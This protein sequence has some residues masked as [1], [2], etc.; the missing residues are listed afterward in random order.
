M[1]KALNLNPYSRWFEIVIEYSRRN[2]TKDTDI[3]PAL[4][5][6]ARAF[7]DITKDRYCAGMWESELLQSLCW[8]RQTV[9][10]HGTKNR[11]N[12]PP[13]MDLT[14]PTAYRA[15]SWSWA[16]VNGGR[17][18]MYNTAIDNQI[19]IKNIATPLRISLEPLGEDLY[20]ELKSGFLSIKGS[21]FTLGD[22]C[23]EYWKAVSESWEEYKRLPPKGLKSET[24]QYPALHEYSLSLLN[25]G[26]R[27]TFEFEQQHRRHPNQTFT[28]FLIAQ[29]EGLSE[30]AR[31]NE[32]YP[33]TG[34]ANLLLLESTG[35]KNEY[36]RIGVLNLGRPVELFSVV[37]ET[38]RTETKKW[39][40]I[41]DAEWE[42]FEKIPPAA[43]GV[44]EAKAWV[45]IAK[46]APKRTTIRIV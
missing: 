9:Q 30:E 12:E 26:S 39:K 10:L 16:A 18:T 1:E 13:N 28:A 40:D 5:G 6:V 43:V 24:Y 17:V 20:G 38:W 7:S 11:M 46:L 19:A 8:W 45:E 34:S 27:E 44:P 31:D 22:L 2:Y 29:V 36:R 14:K 42:R 37:P 25:K 21:L 3:L 41:G 15:P 35:L 4:G 33:M 32:N 23:A